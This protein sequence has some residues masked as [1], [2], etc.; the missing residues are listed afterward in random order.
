L[1]V[2]NPLL[3]SLFL[4]QVALAP[5]LVVTSVV[6]L[7]LASGTFGLLLKEPLRMSTYLFK[8]KKRLL[9]RLDRL[10]KPRRLHVAKQGRHRSTLRL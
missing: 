1:C 6:V 8:I 10:K 4:S 7:L 2:L 5:V 9:K 3:F